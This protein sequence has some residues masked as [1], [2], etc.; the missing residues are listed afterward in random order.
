MQNPNPI[1]LPVHPNQT[2]GPDAAPGRGR[3]PNTPLAALVVKVCNT[4]VA[5]SMFVLAGC[6]L[7]PGAEDRTPNTTDEAR[8]RE[9]AHVAN[10][11]P[12]PAEAEVAAA[13]REPSAEEQSTDPVDVEI[14]RQIREA[15]SMNSAL[16]VEA[17]TCTIV[18]RGGVV[19]L[20]GGVADESE[21]QAI[22]SV[23]HRTRGV[24]RVEDLL[25]LPN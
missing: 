10:P 21:R 7:T 12:T 2:Q 5:L 24:S 15:V 1:L 20:R 17:R 14:T 25:S 3:L 19:T 8:E 18:T 22:A 6:D 13:L 4:G 23:A 11:T 16:S 9:V